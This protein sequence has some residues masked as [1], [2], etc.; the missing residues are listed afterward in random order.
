MVDMS[1]D[2]SKV[3]IVMVTFNSMTDIKLS[4]PILS[5]LN[6]NVV[7]VDNASTD[8][9]PEFIRDGFPQVKLVSL[10]KNVGFAA[11]CNRGC[12][13]LP[14]SEFLLFLNP[15]VLPKLETVQALIAYADA[16][17]A[18]GI[19]GPRLDNPDGSLQRS[20]R[21]VPTVGIV[22]LRRTPLG[23][24]FPRTLER[25]LM[26]DRSS[27]APFAVDWL[28][29]ACMLLRR[30]AFVS[31]GGMDERFFLYFEDVDVCLRMWNSGWKVHYIP[32]VSM[33]HAHNRASAQRQ[34][35]LPKAT[36]LHIGSALKFF[37]KYPRLILSL[38]PSYLP[39]SSDELGEVAC[40]KI[41]VSQ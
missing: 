20:F 3:S 17:P 5:D 15:D 16:H 29:G 34:W 36:R 13:E 28:L 10:G 22:L 24:L 19:V 4:V 18:V 7:V 2:V 33:V 21:A 27:S 8:G 6:L 39:S 1:Q 30:S 31:I 37:A 26:R 12:L 35:I 11:A 38:V 32:T 40:E 25:F 14:D 23:R 9:T 41:R